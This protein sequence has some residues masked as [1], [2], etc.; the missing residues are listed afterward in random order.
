MKYVLK[1]YPKLVEYLNSLGLERYETRREKAVALY[2]AVRD[3]IFYDPFNIRLEVEE[4]SPDQTLER[5][6]GH[7]IDKAVLFNTLCQGIDL[8]A[9]LGLAK[10]KNHMGTEKLERA[11]GTNVLVPHG[12]SNC[13]LDGEWVKCTPAFNASLCEKLGVAPLEWDGE[14]DSLFQENDHGGGDFMEY[15]E[16]YGHFE[17]IP[18]DLITSLMKKEYPNCFNEEGEW[19][20]KR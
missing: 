20:I 18:I 1:E 4:L 6:R 17:E 8:E 2:L 3:D 19:I 7:C 9:R 16:D 13:Y 15:I 12:Y 5:R 10:V 14:Q 11:L